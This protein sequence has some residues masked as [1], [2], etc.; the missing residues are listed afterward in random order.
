MKSQPLNPFNPK[1]VRA[2]QRLDR[3][4]YFRNLRK[5]HGM[6]L[7]EVADQL[8][9]SKSK[10]SLVET[11]KQDLAP[12]LQ[13]K[14]E[15]ILRP[16]LSAHERQELA[17][18]RRRESEAGQ[19]KALAESF[20]VNLAKMPLLPFLPHTPEQQKVAGLRLRQESERTKRLTR[21]YGSLANY[22]ELQ[23]MRKEIKSQAQQ[24]K[25]L[26]MQNH[27]E[28]VFARKLIRQIKGLKARFDRIRSRRSHASDT[29]KKRIRRQREVL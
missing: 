15:G 17:E 23:R 6:T 26:N 22:Q 14:L 13:E 4:I 25:I 1:V 10:L 5:Q 8:G 11:G 16:D 7:Q 21:E 27:S 18:Q 9:L 29:P 2:M 24:I 20:G 3:G 28:V 19:L 12:E